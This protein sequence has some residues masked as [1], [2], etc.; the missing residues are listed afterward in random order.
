MDN[1]VW[2]IVG[3]I[4]LFCIVGNCIGLYF[5]VKSRWDDFWKG[6]FNKDKQ[7]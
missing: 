5:L 2:Y 7:L 4:F 6:V 1:S 3:V